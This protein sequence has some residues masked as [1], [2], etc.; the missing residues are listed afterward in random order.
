MTNLSPTSAPAAQAASVRS[1]AAARPASMPPGPLQPI[2]AVLAWLVPGAGH[3]FLGYTRRAILIAGGVFGLFAGGLFVGGIDCV[4]KRE[5]FFWFLGQALAGPVAFGT[6][7]IHQ[8]HFKA[9]DP[10]SVSNLRKTDD[11]VRARRGSM[12]S[13]RPE[14]TRTTTQVE[15]DDPAAGRKVKVTVPVFRK[16][17]PGEFPPNIS[18]LGRVNELGTLFCTVAGFMNLIAVIDAGQLR[19]NRRAVGGIRA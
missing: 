19:R 14:E 3:L 12:R 9:L 6:D 17:G 18:S 1:A 11:L 16:A 13:A 5:N 10:A 4:D 7:Y 2:A 15:I 8:N